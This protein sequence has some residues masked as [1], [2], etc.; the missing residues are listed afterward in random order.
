M[1]HQYRSRKRKTRRAPKR[2][3]LAEGRYSTPTCRQ[4]QQQLLAAR[5]VEAERQQ[6]HQPQSCLVSFRVSR[7]YNFQKISVLVY[8]KK[9]I[10]YRLGPVLRRC[11]VEATPRREKTH[12]RQEATCGALLTKEKLLLILPEP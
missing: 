7:V 11:L 9:C 6:Q 2:G 8:A 1:P 10:R 4:Q 5:E 3:R 12:V